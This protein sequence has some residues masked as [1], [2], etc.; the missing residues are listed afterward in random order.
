M[1]N[2]KKIK[3][4]SLFILVYFFLLPFYKI[5]RRKNMPILGFASDYFARN[6]K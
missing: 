5:F 1:M 6:I 2:P 4:Y 3:E